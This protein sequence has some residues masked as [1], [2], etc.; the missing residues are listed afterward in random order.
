MEN[1]QNIY[2]TIEHL[3]SINTNKK[4]K[5]A[6]LN[7]LIDDNNTELELRHNNMT[8]RG[9]KVSD[10]RMQKEYGQKKFIKP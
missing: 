4:N 2:S 1:I 9:D 8:T 6:T 7:D 10:Y 5:K 3:Q